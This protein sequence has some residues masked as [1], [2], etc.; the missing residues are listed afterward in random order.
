MTQLQANLK[1]LMEEKDNRLSNETLNSR[2]VLEKTAAL[3]RRIEELESELADS[4]VELCSGLHNPA[5]L[6]H[7]FSYHS[8]A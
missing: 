3:N 5:L 4:K 7:I 2:A 1:Q 6:V 8:G